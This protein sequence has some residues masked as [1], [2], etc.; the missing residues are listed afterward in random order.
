[1]KEMLHVWI[2]RDLKVEIQEY[3]KEHDISLSQLTRKLLKE[4]LA[5]NS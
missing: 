5:K 4:Y 3:C 1:M 2:E